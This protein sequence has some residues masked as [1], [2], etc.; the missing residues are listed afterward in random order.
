MGVK[1]WEAIAKFDQR[2][3]AADIKEA[4]GSIP[5]EARARALVSGFDL[6]F[7]EVLALREPVSVPCVGA[8][9]EGIDPIHVISGC[10]IDGLMTGLLLAELQ[11]ASKKKEAEEEERP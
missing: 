6:D 10:W 1:I 3:D 5:D 2:K 4:G 8:I 9:A 11:T 7:E